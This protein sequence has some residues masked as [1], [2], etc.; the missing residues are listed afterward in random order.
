VDYI[1]CVQLVIAMLLA[2]PCRYE[3]VICGYRKVVPGTIRKKPGGRYYLPTRRETINVLWPLE[4]YSVLETVQLE[5]PLNLACSYDMST[6]KAVKTSGLM[7]YALNL[8]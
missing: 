5:F 4:W 2:A 1:E 7:E 6:H 3:T 8:K